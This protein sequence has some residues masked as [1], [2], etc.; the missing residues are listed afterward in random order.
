MPAG[1]D[2][3]LPASEFAASLS[4]DRSRNSGENNPVSCFITVCKPVL[5]D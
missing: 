2:T 1:G 5:D 3:V 4:R